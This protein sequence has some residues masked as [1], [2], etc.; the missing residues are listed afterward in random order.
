VGCVIIKI[1]V[2]WSVRDRL[3]SQLCKMPKTGKTPTPE[4]VRVLAYSA[5]EK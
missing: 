2:A 5:R 1:P 4:G 3:K